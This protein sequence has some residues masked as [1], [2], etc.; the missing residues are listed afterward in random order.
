MKDIL[1]AYV[2]G[3]FTPKNP[4]KYGCGIILI[5]PN[6]NEIEFSYANDNVEAVKLRNVA[7]ELSASMKAMIEAIEM[8]YEELI[9]YHDYTGVS[10]WVTGEWRCKNDI[11][12]AYKNF[13]EKSVNSKLEVHFVKVKGHNGDEYN[14]RVDKLAKK[15]LMLD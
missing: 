11:T 1:V 10:A 7:G 13:Y 6:G 15:S 3:S 2:D 12:K 4:T 8:G 14:E 5:E 9:I